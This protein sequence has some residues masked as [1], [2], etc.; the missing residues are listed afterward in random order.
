MRHSAAPKL[1][2]ALVL[3][4]ALGAKCGPLR[5]IQFLE[6]D[7]GKLLASGAPLVVLSRIGQVFDPATVAVEI[8]GVDLVAA[9][10]LVPP[11][12]G[13]GGAVV[14]GPDLVM[15]SNFTYDPTAP[16][17]PRLDVQV[18]GL[19]P[20]AHDVTISANKTASG[21]PGSASR[22]FSVVGGFA[23]A[24]PALTA[25][26]LPGGPA[27]TGSAGFLANQALGQPLAAPPIGFVGG[28]SLRSGHI[29]AAERSIAGGP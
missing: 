25:A 23:E 22:S 17:E 13:A 8:D 28:E 27:T 19:S 21:E 24:V 10:G 1:L 26:G 2:L 12:V 5:V 20:G 11:F 6:P 9:L 3:C 29:E 18:D 14:V 7:D 16:G 4:A 15:V